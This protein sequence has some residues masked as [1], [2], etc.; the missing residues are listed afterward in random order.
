MCYGECQTSEMKAVAQLTA[1]KGIVRHGLDEPISRDTLNERHDR[2]ARAAGGTSL[3]IISSHRVLDR[4]LGSKHR[5]HVSVR[6]VDGHIGRDRIE[7][8]RRDNQRVRF[9]CDKV[10]PGIDPNG[11]QRAFRH[12]TSLFG[13]NQ[14]VE[15]K[16]PTSSR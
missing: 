9:E 15:L 14:I 4:G 13:L 8:T 2:T 1:T 5:L 12:F 3:N 11:E 16:T 10:K 6:D 7:S